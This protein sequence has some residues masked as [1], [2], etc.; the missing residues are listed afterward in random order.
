MPGDRTL[1]DAWGAWIEQ[2]AAWEWYLTLTFAEIVHPEQ[3]ERKWRA[4]VK[5]VEGRH[6]RV[7]SWVRAL[8]YQRRGVIH[9]HALLA[10]ME[11][12]A[13]N[14]ARQ[15]WPWGFSWIEAYEPGRGANYYLGK[16]L[17]KGG[18]IDVGGPLHKTSQT[19]RLLPLRRR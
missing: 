7:V 14:A 3:A 19:Q 8:E 13:Y 15:C 10:G 5:R 18:E 11:F 2:L 6:G 1:Q 16:Y 12:L 4:F 9:F 17:A